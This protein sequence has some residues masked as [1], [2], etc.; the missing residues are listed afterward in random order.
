MSTVNHFPELHRDKF[1]PYHLIEADVACHLAVKCGVVG[2]YILD[3]CLDIVVNLVLGAVVGVRPI[4][5]VMRLF[6]CCIIVVAGCFSLLCG[7]CLLRRR[8]A[9]ELA[10]ER[11]RRVRL[12][13]LR[14]LLD[15]KH[16]NACHLVFKRGDLS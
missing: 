8:V 10:E 3:H 6:R 7:R 13:V 12:F 2:I 4:L 11:R 14:P 16:L 5:F 15:G 9:V 1:I